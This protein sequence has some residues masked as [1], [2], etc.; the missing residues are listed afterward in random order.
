[1][2]ER[3]IRFTP[4]AVR[5]Y[6]CALLARPPPA[7]CSPLSTAH[8][9]ST[10]FFFFWCVCV[11]PHFFFSCLLLTPHSKVAVVLYNQLVLVCFVSVRTYM[12]RGGERDKYIQ[13]L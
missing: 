12:H 8:F 3:Q 6:W 11:F 13:S 10:R 4:S 2:K 7:P 5:V 9:I 1:V